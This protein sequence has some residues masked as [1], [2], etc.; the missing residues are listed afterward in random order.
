MSAAVQIG[1][2]LEPVG[3][4]PVVIEDDVV[5]GGNC[6]VYE[7]TIVKRRSV[8]GTGVILNGSTKVYDLVNDRDR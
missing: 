5:V 4:V 6:G 7:G 8:L 1:G 2:V 3:S